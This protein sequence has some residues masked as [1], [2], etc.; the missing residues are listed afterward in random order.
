MI[1]INE[2]LG[3]LKGNCR[4]MLSRRWTA[5]VE[6]N[7]PSSTYASRIIAKRRVTKIGASDRLRPLAIRR[8]RI[9]SFN[10]PIFRYFF[11]TVLNETAAPSVA[12]AGQT[13]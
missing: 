3:E 11:Y 6:K 9:P 12:F 4:G 2:I 7:L 8:R 1:L 10:L 13:T 5:V